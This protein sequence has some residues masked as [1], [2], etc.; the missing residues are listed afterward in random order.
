M[1]ETNHGSECQRRNKQRRLIIIK[2]NIY[3]SYTAW[4]ASKK[5][6]IGKLLYTDKWLHGFAKL[7]IGE[8]DYGLMHLSFRFVILIVK[9]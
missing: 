9:F 5:E 7:I 3:H 2:P 6:Y 1:T 8:T 4:K